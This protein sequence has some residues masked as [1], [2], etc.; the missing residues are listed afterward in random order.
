MNL[1]Y[2]ILSYFSQ[3]YIELLGF[4]TSLICVFLNIKQNAWAWFWAIV[5]SIIYSIIF[6]QFGLYSDMELQAF[7]VILSLY[8]WY[9]W[10][11][12]QDNAQFNIANI[13]TNKIPLFIALV[14]LFSFISGFFHAKIKGVSLPYLDSFLTAI[15]LLGQ[16]FLAKKYIENWWLWIL[17][18]LGYVFLYTYKE[19]Y[20]TA[21]LY[22][23]LLVLAVKGLQTWKK[24]Q[25]S[26]I[27]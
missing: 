20:I 3:N 13:A 1:I 16:Y 7:F 4:I 25:K 26:L 23:L 8:G 17:A 21:I 2:K 15:S 5:S 9:N 12:G 22:L 24:Q 27:L 18:N 19:L 11:L 6:Y 10:K 14:L